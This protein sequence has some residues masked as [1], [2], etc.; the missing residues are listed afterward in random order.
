[1]NPRQA[2]DSFQPSCKVF[3]LRDAR[4]RIR[5]GAHHAKTV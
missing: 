3:W 1:M 2:V 5:T 4:R